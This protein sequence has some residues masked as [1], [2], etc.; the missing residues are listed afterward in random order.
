MHAINRRKALTVVASVPAAVALAATPAL[1]GED[2]ELLRLWEEF[3]TSLPACKTTGD[4]Y[5]EVSCKV[6]EEIGPYWELTTVKDTPWRA[7]FHSSWHDDVS[8]KI[9]PLKLKAHDFRRAQELAQMAQAS[10]VAERRD[11]E[12]VAKRKHKAAAAE[13]AYN[14][15]CEHRWSIVEKIAETPAEGLTGLAIKLAIWRHAFDEK[16]NN[17]FHDLLHTTHDALVK[18]AGVDYAAQVERW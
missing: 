7:V 3:K 6:A 10:L 2:V 8:Q 5:D 9:V 4:A 11:Q 15:A 13:R 12:K 16:T 18:L 14:A 1:A 17:E